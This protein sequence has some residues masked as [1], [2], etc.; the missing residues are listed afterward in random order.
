MP[1]MP[2][3]H[4]LTL[5]LFLQTGVALAAPPIQ[6]VETRPVESVLGNPSLPSPQPVWIDMIRGAKKT[7]DIEQFYLSTWPGEP[8]EGVLD[9][10][11]LADVGSRIF[12]GGGDGDPNMEASALW[13]P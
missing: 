11:H 2:L 1:R 5:V 6:L 10:M 9:A 12:S 13:K 3:R 7:L 4:L 8:M